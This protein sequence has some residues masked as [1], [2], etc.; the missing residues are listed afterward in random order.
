MA[1][2][3]PEGERY[4]LNPYIG[5]ESQIVLESPHQVWFSCVLFL[6]IDS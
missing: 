5:L 1:H 6:S 2:C 4:Y 3:N